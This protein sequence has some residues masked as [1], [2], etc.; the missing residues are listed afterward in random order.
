MYYCERPQ[1]I[2]CTYIYIYIYIP[3]HERP[4]RLPAEAD[5]MLSRGFKDGR[6]Q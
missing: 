3:T 6:P 1:R 2:P 5:E 4:Q